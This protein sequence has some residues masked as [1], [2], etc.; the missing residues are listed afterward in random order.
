LLWALWDAIRCPTLLL[1]GAQSDLLA[2][3][4]A[5]EMTQRGPRPAL[6]EI[7]GVG[8]APMLFDP[9]QIAPVAEFLRS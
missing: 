8:H 4:T 7:Q 1:R 6:I 3:S 5:R 9:I 2:A